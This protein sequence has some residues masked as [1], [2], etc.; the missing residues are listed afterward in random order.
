M[1]LK[2]ICDLFNIPLCLGIFVLHILNF[3]RLFLKESEES[4]FFFRFKIFQFSDHI[5]DQLTDFSQI[6]HLHILQCCIGKICHLLLGSRSVLKDLVC[7]LNINLCSKFLHHFLL[8]WCECRCFRFLLRLFD[9][10][11]FFFLFHCAK[12]RFQGQ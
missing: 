1:L 7:I 4:T 6:L 10:C 2:R 12:I 9:F 8:C 3:R 11:N 5:C